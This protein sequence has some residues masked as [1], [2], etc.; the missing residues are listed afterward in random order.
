MKLLF[1]FKCNDIVKLPN[2]LLWRRCACGAVQGRY[3]EDGRHA[4]YT[5]DGCLLGINNGT[6]YEVIHH[7]H[8]RRPIGREFTAFVISDHSEYVKKLQGEEKGP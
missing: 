6:F 4:E 3:L 8:A 5:G 2:P 1:C 7:H